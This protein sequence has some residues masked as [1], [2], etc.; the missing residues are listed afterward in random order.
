M[1]S[2]T[3]VDARRDWRLEQIAHATGG[4]AVLVDATGTVV[5]RGSG[6]ASFLG[7]PP[8]FDATW[9]EVHAGIAREL[10]QRPATDAEL[11]LEVPFGS[12]SE[13]NRLFVRVL[14]IPETLHGGYL[15]IFTRRQSLD[16]L[17][18][19]LR[20]AAQMRRLHATWRQAAHDL[21]APLNAIAVN[22]DL[23]RQAVDDP[24]GNGPARHA[25]R[26]RVDLLQREVTRLSRMLQ[27]LLAQSGP[28]REEARLFGLRRLLREVLEL[29]SPQAERLGIRISLLVPSARLAVLVPRDHLKQAL[30]NL[31]MNAL[32][33][34]PH[35]GP[36][37]LEL[38][39]EGALAVIQVHDHGV[40]IAARDR[41]RI[42]RMH[43]TTKPGGSGIGL[44]TTRAAI[45]AMGG[46]LTLDSLPGAGTTARIELPLADPDTVTEAPC[47]MS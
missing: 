43:F 10:S 29:V 8:D 38:C 21:R 4:S 26:N 18:S 30:L 31:L 36:I 13:A 9:R 6:A 34:M 44:F 32:E 40:G 42:F 25:A 45:E 37:E 41:E 16:A 19:D 3:L 33:A 1:S 47:S 17:Q 14:R 7:D 39:A 27:V 20:L 2:A 28:P 11:A 5:L 22:L 24:A 15:A 12:A 46:S 23:I 35:G